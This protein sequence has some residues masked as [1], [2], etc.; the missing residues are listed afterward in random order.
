MYTFEY[1]RIHFISISL[2][3]REKELSGKTKFFELGPSLNCLQQYLNAVQ[4]SKLHIAFKYLKNEIKN[5]FSH[6]NIYNI[7]TQKAYYLSST[8]A[9]VSSLSRWA[10][11][12]CVYMCCISIYTCVVYVRIHVLYKYVYMCCISMYTCVVYVSI[13]VYICV[14]RL[15]AC[16]C[17]MRRF[18]VFCGIWSFDKYSILA[19]YQWWTANMQNFLPN[20]MLRHTTPAQYTKYTTI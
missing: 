15:S 8:K 3:Q 18:S 9:P 19:M 10:S 14:W 6:C 16:H 12:I 13:H 4:K 20:S 1:L 2:V 7:L 5:N 17:V 11:D